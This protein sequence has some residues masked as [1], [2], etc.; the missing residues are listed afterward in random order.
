MQQDFSTSKQYWVD[1][2]QNYPVLELPND[3]MRP[4]EQQFN[5]ATERLVLDEEITKQVKQLV[6]KHHVTE[7]M[8]FLGLISI[9]LAKLSNQEELVIG[10]PVSGRTHKDTEQMLGMF[11]NT[12]A[13]RVSPSGDKSFAAYLAELKEQVL[14]AQEH[15]TYPFEDLVG[16]VAKKRD[17]SRHP[18][19][20]VMVAYQNSEM[21]LSLLEIGEW[22]KFDEVNEQVAKFDLNFA[23]ADDGKQITIELN[24]ATALFKKNTIHV[25]LKRLFKLLNHVLMQDQAG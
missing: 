1:S 22:Q 20:D 17:L 8:F 24:Y 23:V 10:T 5:G 14:M 3:F 13:I 7:Y 2:L 18:I 19:F 21:F 15:Q 6:Q 4:K 11:V 16:H 9:L 25:Y 12:L